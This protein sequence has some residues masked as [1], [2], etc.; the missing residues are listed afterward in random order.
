MI[1]Q[2]RAD[3][4]AFRGEVRAVT[5]DMTTGSP[6]SFSADSDAYDRTLQPPPIDAFSQL[7]TTDTAGVPLAAARCLIRLDD[8]TAASG[9]N[10]GEFALEAGSFS[11]DDL[12]AC[13]ASGFAREARDIRFTPADL[14]ASSFSG[15]PRPGSVVS[16]L[17]VSGALVFWC[18][19]TDGGLGDPM[20]AFSIVVRDSRRP[21]QPLVDIRRTFTSDSRGN[22]TLSESTDVGITGPTLMMRIRDLE[23]L[24]ADPLPQA[25]QLAAEADLLGLPHFVIVVIPEQTLRYAY[26]FTLNQNFVIEAEF[27]IEVRSAPGGMGAAGVMGR[28]FAGLSD[29]IRASRVGGDA[30]PI[31]T[32]V[33]KL[34]EASTTAADSESFLPD[35]PPQTGNLCGAVGVEM[36]IGMSGGLWWFLM[37]PTRRRHAVRFR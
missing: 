30:K 3:I 1:P 33:N 7:T 23:Q 36:L 34:I 15:S 31:E 6:G 14:L 4:R 16:S 28:P 25:A 19:D 20:V 29:L 2:V 8:P 13:M 27:S 21:D 35:T 11:N 10:P 18:S 5:Q 12:V 26:P 17:F 32:A 37:R 24:R 9:N 22:V